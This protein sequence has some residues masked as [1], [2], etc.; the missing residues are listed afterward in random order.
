MLDNCIWIG[1]GMEE[2][3]QSE[4]MRALHLGKSMKDVG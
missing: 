3:G 2:T 1:A 4:L